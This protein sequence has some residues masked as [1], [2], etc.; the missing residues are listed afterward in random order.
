MPGAGDV[1]V[2]VADA[3]VIDHA[4]SLAAGRTRPTTYNRDV[5]S[6]LIE[7]RLSQLSARLRSLREELRVID[8][9]L[10]HLA[11]EAEDKGMRAMVAETPI[12]SF[13]YRDARSHAE[14]MAKHRDHVK[15]S[16]VELEQRQDQLLDRMI[17]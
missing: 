7:R 16:I 5:G 3:Q 9:Q 10:A 17:G 14:A 11:E 4:R 12:A 8:E 6:R 13:E 15:A 1:V 2:A